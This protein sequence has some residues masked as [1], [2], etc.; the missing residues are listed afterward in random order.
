MKSLPKNS[1]TFLLFIFLT[2]S[3]CASAD[4]MNI[5]FKK[6][7]HATQTYGELETIDHINN[8]YEITL[9]AENIENVAIVKHAGKAT[10]P[11]K[12][13]TLMIYISAD[14]DLR[15]FAIRNIKQMTK[16]GSNNYINIIVHLDIKLAGNKKVTKRYYIKKDKILHL[17]ADDP[18]TQR[19]D[20]GNPETLI[21]F[22]NWGI[23]E[24]P[25]T[26]YGLILW[27]HGTGP[28]NPRRGRI[29]KLSELFTFNPELN[30]VEVDRSIGFFDLLNAYQQE[31]R[32]ICWDDTTGNYL[33]C[34]NVDYAL[35]KVYTQKLK[36]Q[37]FA[38]IGFDACL[39]Q[40]AE[41]A[42][43]VA[44]YADIMIGS[45][46]VILGTGWP[47]IEMLKPYLQHSL[48][49]EEFS[50]H[51]VYTY[52]NA[53]NRITNDYTLSAIKLKE[54]SLLKDNIDTVSNLLIACLKLD[55]N[56]SVKKTITTCRSRLLCTHFDEPS[57][58]DLHHLY[59]N[60]LAS[61]KHFNLKNKQQEALLKKDLHTA[62]SQGCAL[63]EAL[64]LAN[65][66][67][68][69]LSNAKGLSIYFPTK[70]IYYS[71]RNHPFCQNNNWILFLT[72]Y[73]NV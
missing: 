57:F 11:K 32:G 38:F 35:K 70:R 14:N 36:G 48:S 54:F 7:L 10:Q 61:I 45:Q 24:F 26:N 60:L 22:C 16:V 49:K 41:I 39:M 2:Q 4:H 1:I 9:G 15:N 72:Q 33:S 34:Q 71:Y 64:T 65:V 40:H 67:G 73:L 69:N 63:I 21:S 12:D 68:K 37:K 66:A 13:W 55:V 23:T 62:L 50:R 46:E 8:L 18:A 44:K 17:N 58:I 3:L 20:S 59:K 5:F 19:M 43:I 51:I 28:L 27:N 25:A 56:K 42:D 30:K 53:Y 6:T 52:R 29:I 31:D 47:Y